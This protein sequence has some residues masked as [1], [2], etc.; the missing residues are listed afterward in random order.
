MS[1]V[2]DIIITGK[3]TRID[4]VTNTLYALSRLKY[5]PKTNDEE[6]F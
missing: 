3:M 2:A 4:S 1:S 6:R 5:D